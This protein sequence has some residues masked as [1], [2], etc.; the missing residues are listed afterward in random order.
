MLKERRCKFAIAG[1]L[2]ANFYRSEIRVTEDI[3]IMLYCDNPIEQIREIFD[4]FGYT[5]YFAKLHDLK[6]SPM[7]NKKS[8]PIL[9]AIGR[10]K[11]QGVGLDFLLPEIPWFGNAID[12]AQKIS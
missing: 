6:R 3:D 10:G 9:I 5:P 2:A 12:R 7:M 4:Q 11:E 1:G 8:Q